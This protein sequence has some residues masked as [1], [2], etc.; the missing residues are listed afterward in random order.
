LVDSGREF[1]NSADALVPQ[2]KNNVEDV[3]EYEPPGVGDCS[4][5]SATYS[6][7]SGG[8]VSLI[9]S[10]SAKEESAFLD[11]TANGD[12][13]FFLTQARL[14]SSDVDTSF[15]VYDAHVCSDS[16]P[17]PPPPAPPSPA[18]QGDACQSPSSPPGEET[19]SSLTYKGPGN[20][21]PPA[22]AP[23]PKPKP[24]TKAQLLAKALRSCKAKKVKKKRV[25]C[26]LQ[27]RKKYGAKKASK[28]KQ[29]AKGKKSSR[30]KGKR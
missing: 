15:D 13:A 23:P 25:S 10:G 12:E 30:E 21:A 28:S 24:L 4:S 19:P 16:S 1:F 7:A 27:A 29:R 2:D 9:S 6:T 17:C 8:C 11:A 14:T 3:Y 5:S 26:E 22:A 18:C 20:A